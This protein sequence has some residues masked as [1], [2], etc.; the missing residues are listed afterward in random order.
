VNRLIVD[1]KLTYDRKSSSINV[2]QT[3][4]DTYTADLT[5]EWEISRYFRLSFGGGAS[6]I[7]NRV[8]KDAGVMSFNVNSQ[9]IINF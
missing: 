2:G 8:Q 4:T 5:G 7:V 3:N 9:L 1:G 6:E